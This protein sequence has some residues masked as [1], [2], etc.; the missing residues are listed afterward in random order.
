[1]ERGEKRGAVAAWI[2]GLRGREGDV[3]V[4]EQ[5]GEATAGG[6]RRGGSG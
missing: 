4:G 2:G 1:M 6:G 3:E 5:G